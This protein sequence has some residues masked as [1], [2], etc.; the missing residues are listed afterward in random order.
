MIFISIILNFRR[1]C[2]REQDGGG[3]ETINNI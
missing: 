2:G 3:T 1:I